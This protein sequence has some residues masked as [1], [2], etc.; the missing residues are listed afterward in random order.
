[1]LVLTQGVH[2]LSLCPATRGRV[3]IKPFTLTSLAMGLITAPSTLHLERPHPTH[4]PCL[5]APCSSPQHTYHLAPHA[6]PDAACFLGQQGSG[7]PGGLQ[8]RGHVSEQTGEDI[9]GG[10]RDST[11]EP[12]PRRSQTLGCFLA[13]LAFPTSGPLHWLLSLLDQLHPSALL[14]SSSSQASLGSSRLL[15]VRRTSPPECTLLSFASWFVG[16]PSSPPQKDTS[17]RQGLGPS[18]PL[19]R[20]ELSILCGTQL[21]QDKIHSWAVVIGDPEGQAA[22]DPTL[23]LGGA[24]MILL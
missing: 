13:S 24:L 1:M 10:K 19:C 17:Y 11:R 5:P 6:G 8:G 21:V 20:P 15:C 18:C 9:P 2:R 7:A 4:P 16:A 22:H 14:P 3:R 12:W 23:L